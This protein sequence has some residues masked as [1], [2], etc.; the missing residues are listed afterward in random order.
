MH[1][2][3][4]APPPP[5]SPPRTAL[6]PFYKS[7]TAFR[8]LLVEPNVPLQSR[9]SHSALPRTSSRPASLA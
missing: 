8:F 7:R 2:T 1:P 6:S 4:R 5:A 3:A 9:M